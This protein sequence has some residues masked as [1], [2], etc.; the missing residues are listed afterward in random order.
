[1]LREEILQ[2]AEKCVCGRRASDY[3]KPEDNFG[4]IADFWNVYLEAAHED[5][6]W[7]LTAKDV[8]AMMILL[9]EA[10]IAR[11]SNIDSWVD[12]AGYAACGGEIEST[13]DNC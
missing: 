8:A 11:G 13:S 5:V 1:M 9:K 7:S 2:N 12:I 10:R 6:E 3:G 4:T